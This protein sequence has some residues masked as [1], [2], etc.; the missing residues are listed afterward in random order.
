MKCS[1]CGGS[2]KVS[3]S[4]EKSAKSVGPQN[5]VGNFKNISLVS[6]AAKMVSK[7]K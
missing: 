3:D 6:K 4:G 7:G 1:A 5:S 2:G